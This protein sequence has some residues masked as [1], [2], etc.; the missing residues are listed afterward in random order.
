MLPSQKAPR[1]Y[2]TRN[3]F[4]LAYSGWRFV[5]AICGGTTVTKREIQVAVD[6]AFA[7]LFSAFVRPVRFRRSSRVAP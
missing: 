5:K 2:R 1:S 7:S 6:M 3:H 4:W